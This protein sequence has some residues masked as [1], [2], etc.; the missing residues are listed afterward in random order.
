MWCGGVLFKMQFH[1][2]FSLSLLKDGLV[3]DFWTSG[4][5]N[6]SWRRGIR[7]GVEA[8]QLESLIQILTPIQLTSIPDRWSW[9]LDP[10]GVFSV[11]SMR[12]YIDSISPS[13]SGVGT[14]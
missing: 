4:G 11:S 3:S 2:L 10:S 14:R 5:W 7:E 13:V 8:E 9:S 1:R 6:F 12:R